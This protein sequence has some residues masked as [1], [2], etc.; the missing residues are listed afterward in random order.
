MPAQGAWGTGVPRH[1]PPPAL[2][3]NPHDPD[4]NAFV[5]VDLTMRDCTAQCT[6]PK[7]AGLARGHWVRLVYFK[8]AAIENNT[9]DHNRGINLIGDNT[10]GNV[11]KI[12]V[13]RNR[14]RNLD[15]RTSDGGTCSGANVLAWTAN[16]GMCGASFVQVNG[17]LR[18]PSIEIAWNEI[19]NTPGQGH[20]ED[21]INT[22]RAARGRT[23]ARARQLH[24]WR[25]PCP[26]RHGP[27]HAGRH[28]CRRWR[29]T[30]DAAHA[31]A[32]IRVTGNRV[33]S[34][35][36]VAIAAATGHDIVIARNRVVSSGRLPDGRFINQTFVGIFIW[37]YCYNAVARGVMR[38]VVATNN[39]VGYNFVN[40][41]RGQGAQ[42]LQ[43]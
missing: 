24:P 37:D 40:G 23:A 28:Q 21:H 17:F 26:P 7:Q 16:N 11:H 10:F 6:H 22:T 34:S 13:L 42:R 30:G 14:F 1:R 27:H 15:G 9:A 3:T 29:S 5:G 25:L 4:S 20:S 41:V 35:A 36:N 19:I 39:L 2:S 18:V 31:P 33:V 43:V 38:D 32:H 12:K 8:A